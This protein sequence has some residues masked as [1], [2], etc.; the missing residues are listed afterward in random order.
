MRSS[1]KTIVELYKQDNDYSLQF[2]RWFLKPIGAW[3]ALSTI[4]E[5]ILSKFLRLICQSLVAVIVIPSLLYIIV[6]EKDF[7][8]KLKAIGPASHWLMGALNYCS[9]LYQQKHIRGSVE[10][11]ESDWRLTRSEH[12]RKVMLKN[13][14]VGR[15]ISVVCALIMQIGVLCFVIVRGLQPTP[16]VMGNTTIMLRRLPCPIFNLLIDTRFSPVYE[17]MLTLQYIS[18]M[19]V[20]NTTVGA[21][22]LAAVFAAH[23]CGQLDVVISRLEELVDK[24][25]EVHQVQK[26]LANLVE[27]HLRTLKYV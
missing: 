3:P 9:L 24:Q 25:T 11:M 7:R 19:I 18:A 22:A 26:G 21:C 2:I 6:E 13:A 27:H 20:N 15:V 17:I 16:V 4:S 8:M 12:D 5:R 1:R 10:H 23:G 14:R